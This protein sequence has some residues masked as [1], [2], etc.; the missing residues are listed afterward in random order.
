MGAR[1]RSWRRIFGRSPD[2]ARCLEDGAIRLYVWRGVPNLGD[3]VA[4]EIVAGLSGRPVRVVGKRDPR[5]L[6]ACGS[7][8]HRARGGDIVW[9]AGSLHPGQ[10]PRGGSIDVRAVRGP[11]TRAIL[12]GAGFSCPEVYGDPALL[13]PTIRPRDSRTESGRLGVIPH[14]QDRPTL[15]TRLPDLRSSGDARILDIQGNLD[16][17]LDELMTCERVVSSSL[18]GLVFAE[19]YGIPAHE[20]RL[21]DGVRGADHKFEDYYTGT[22]RDRP[23]PLTPETWHSEPEWIPPTVDPRLAA[24]FPFP[25]ETIS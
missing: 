6:L 20:L 1:I 2:P 24:S 8:I 21:G 4:A 23:A 5:R 10:V 12:V 11:K 3:T 17:F 13:L 18:H 14:Y 15:E 7:V 22:E 19:A 25:K 16:A 9:G